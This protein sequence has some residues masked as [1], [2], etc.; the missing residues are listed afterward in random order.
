MEKN[1]K[2]ILLTGGNDY[3]IQLWDINDDYNNIKTIRTDGPIINLFSISNEVFSSF[4]NNKITLWSNEKYDKIFQVK[5]ANIYILEYLVDNIFSAGMEDSSIIIF[6]IFDTKMTHKKILKGNED[7]VTSIKKIN[8][9][10]IITG[11][12]IG[13]L[14]VWDLMK[15]ELFFEIKSAH[16]YKINCIIQLNCGYFA[17]CSN[18]KS[19]KIWDLN[20]RINVLKFQDAHEKSIKGLIQLSNGMIVSSGKDDIIKVW[21]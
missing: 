2:N 14:L 20:K 16:L 1:N 11:N 13:D 4:E 21:N 8:E 9:K 17:T 19:I 6:N 15:M 10:Y 5:M 3:I 12:Y 18:D 7:I